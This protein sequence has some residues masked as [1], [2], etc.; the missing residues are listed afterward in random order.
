MVFLTVALSLM[1]AGLIARA[2]LV[3]GARADDRREDAG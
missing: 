2:I 1:T 3:V